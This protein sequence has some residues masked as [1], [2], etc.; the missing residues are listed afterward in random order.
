MLCYVRLKLYNMS[1]V[2]YALQELY[3]HDVIW[4]TDCP[5]YIKTTESKSNHSMAKIS[6]EGDLHYVSGHI[7]VRG[8]SLNCRHGWRANWNYGNYA[9]LNHPIYITCYVQSD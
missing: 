7:G 3:I 4:P 2:A 5:S 1:I 9:R 6:I 8:H